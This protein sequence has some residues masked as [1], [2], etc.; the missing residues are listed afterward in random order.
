ML[1]AMMFD[2]DTIAR[3]IEEAYREERA[4][5]DEALTQA[6]VL[7]PLVERR[8]GLSVVLTR[9]TDNLRSHAGEI[10]FPGGRIEASDP[11]VV[12]AALREA[13]E[14]VGLPPERVEVLG[15]LNCYLTRTGY[16]VHPIV[17]M[18]QSPVTLRPQPE[19]VAE[20]F[21]VPLAF[22]LDPSNHQPLDFELDGR[23]YRFYAMPYGDY[24]IWGATAGMLRNLYL[25]LRGER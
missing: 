3:L 22:F 17:G 25:V 8:N 11:T 19:E 14:E 4:R 5:E 16:R 18:L 20:I 7:V 6:A 15:R 23:T 10:S 1:V 2:K 9:R 21:E 12:D 13:Q 24:Y